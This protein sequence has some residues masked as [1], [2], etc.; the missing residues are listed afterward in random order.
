MGISFVNRLITLMKRENITSKYRLA[1]LTGINYKTLNSW[2]T[3][4]VKSPEDKHIEV[5]AAFFHVH[6]A[7]LKYGERQYAPTLKDEVMRIAEQMQEYSPETIR[8]IK[9]IVDALDDRKQI[10]RKAG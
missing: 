5:I 1:K 9:T 3:G 6:P 4:Q 10:K 2:F 7:W 8:K